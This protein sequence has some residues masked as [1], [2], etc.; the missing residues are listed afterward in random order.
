MV[1]HTGYVTVCDPRVADGNV[2]RSTTQTHS[3]V[4]AICGLTP[5]SGFVLGRH[6]GRLTR[7]TRPAA[8]ESP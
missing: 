2:G 6:L 7:V 4:Y 8:A 3:G 5:P 1:H